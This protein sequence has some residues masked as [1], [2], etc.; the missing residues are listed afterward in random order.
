M[1]TEYSTASPSASILTSPDGLVWT[2]RS[3]VKSNALYGITYAANR[4]V[5]IGSAFQRKSPPRALVMSSLDGLSWT[6]NQLPV[7]AELYAITYGQTNF[8]AA[9]S[10][11]SPSPGHRK[12]P[13]ESRFASSGPIGSVGFAW[14]QARSWGLRPRGLLS[15]IWSITMPEITRF[16]S[17]SLTTACSSVSP[18]LILIQ[19]E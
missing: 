1:A 19:L 8:V 12:R 4:F 10:D 7:T 16:Q 13:S 9:G 14:N 15:R 3:M 2:V 5:A 11:S 17:R 18:A 6:S